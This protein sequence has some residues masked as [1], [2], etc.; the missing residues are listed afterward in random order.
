MVSKVIERK[1]CL[2]HEFLCKDMIRHLFQKT[3]RVCENDC[4]KEDGYILL[5]KKIKKIKENYISSVDGSIIFIVDIEV[6]TLKPEIDD[7]YRDKVCMVFSGGI[8]INIKDKIK[9][10]I[11]LNTLVNYKFDSST[12]TFIS[13]DKKVIKEHDEIDIKISGIKYSKKNFSCFGELNIENVDL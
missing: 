9:V 11:P 6:D 7:I 4:T 1:I 2:E 8:F 10:L 13:D 3:K 5:V 12:K